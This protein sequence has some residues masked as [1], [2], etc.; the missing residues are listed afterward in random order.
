M[1][2]MWGLILLAWFVAVRES[3]GLNI[4]SHALS[5]SIDFYKDRP[6]SRALALAFKSLKEL[7]LVGMVDQDAYGCTV[8]GDFVP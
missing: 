7:D 1:L 2:A 8:L 3:S 6:C 5:T 4:G